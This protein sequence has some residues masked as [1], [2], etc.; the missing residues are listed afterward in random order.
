MAA[1]GWGSTEVMRVKMVALAAMAAL[2]PV[3]AH[4]QQE[5]AE[6]R[7]LGEQDA[8]LTMVSTVVTGPQ[9]ARTLTEVIVRKE[10]SPSG[11]DAYAVAVIVDCGARTLRLGSSIFY[12]DMAI[13]ARLPADPDAI[14]TPGTGTIGWQ[15]V[16]YACEGTVPPNEND[17]IKGALPAIAWGR[18]RLGLD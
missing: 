1:S 16:R 4:A 7:I 8:G 10:R 5:D 17:R 9:G 14:D 2:L 11:A 6:F 12:R 13:D 15:I 18:K 3:A